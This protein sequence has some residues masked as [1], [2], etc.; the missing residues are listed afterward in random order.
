MPVPAPE[1]V[2][3]EWRKCGRAVDEATFA[4]DIVA[5]ISDEQ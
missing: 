2:A 5:R 4:R 1:P 3:H